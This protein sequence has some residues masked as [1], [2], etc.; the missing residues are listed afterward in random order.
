[1]NHKYLVVAG[2]V[3]LAGLTGILAISPSAGPGMT[4]SY[5]SAIKDTE[6]WIDSARLPNGRAFSVPAVV[7]GMGKGNE[8][9]LVE[10]SVMGAA[11]DGR[12][13]PEYVDFKWREEFLPQ[14]T[15]SAP[16]DPTS[17]AHQAWRTKWMAQHKALPI[18]SQR[19]FIRNRIPAGTVRTVIEA[20]HHTSRGQL[21]EASIWISFIWTG[22]GIK[23]RWHV[24]HRLPSGIQYDSHEGG[25]EILP[26]GKT[27][28]AAYASTI[29]SDKVIVGLADQNPERYPTT[30]NGTFFPGPSSLAYTD[31]PI[32]GGE[33]LTGFESESDLPE[34]VRLRWA[35]FPTADL[36]LKPG[37]SDV[38]HHFRAIAF[39]GALPRKDE[40]ILVRSR[41]PQDVRDEV[42]AAT[43]NAQPHRVPSSVIYLY[44]V[45]TESGVKLHWRLKR[46]RLDG[47]FVT[48]RDGG[49]EITQEVKDSAIR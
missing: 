14:P 5:N 21:N 19:V 49:D 8:N 11:P 12:D 3:M 42:T 30:V 37:E 29:K 31:R 47:T 7:D 32:S 40:R 1:M 48:V 6:I 35:L 26:A 22:Q 41:V 34:W 20:N 10:M 45:W 28:V 13:L 15:D 9:P 16:D 24:W 2:I 4:L 23:L 17:E 18:R 39:F 33:S 27:M 38:A 25:D 46:S 36:P 44:F 43:L